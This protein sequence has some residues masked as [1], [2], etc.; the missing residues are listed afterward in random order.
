MKIL[1]IFTFVAVCL[2]MAACGNSG[3]V[4]KVASKIK[5]DEQL[6][7][8]DYTVMIDYCGKYAQEAQKI[9]DQI[10][11]LPA[12]S[13]E[14]EKLNDEM[15][16]LTDK[17]PY[18]TEFFEKITTCTQEEIGPDN[19]AL[20]NG[21]APLM[22]FSSPEWANIGGDVNVAGFIEDMPSTDTTGVIS[23]GDGVEVDSVAK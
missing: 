3:D 2:L 6:T 9:Q 5:A 14:S 19:V 18:T 22:W 13:E 11:N 1:K 8:A 16:A 20:I 15:A 17:F 7:Q 23:T 12:D 21:F 4:S 10:N